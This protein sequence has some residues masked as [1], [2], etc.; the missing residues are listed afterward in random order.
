MIELAIFGS[1]MIL[2]LGV[3]LNYGMNY[4][5]RQEA[6]MR[7]FR[8]ALASAA[9][10]VAGGDPIGSASYTVLDDRHIPNPASPFGIGSAV[11][12]SGSGSVGRSFRRQHTADIE[13]ELPRV[14]L[15]LQGQEVDCPSAGTGCVAAGFRTESGITGLVWDGDT[16]RFINDSGS[17]GMADRYEVVYGA[18]SLEA[19]GPD[20]I[21]I[22]DACDG[23]IIGFEACLLQARMITDNGVCTEQCNRGKPPGS[24]MDCAAICAQPMH[25]PWYAGGSTVF[26]VLD[27]LFGIVRS[28]AQV[29]AQDRQAMGVQP[30]YVKVTNTDS[31]LT[32]TES[33]GGI[34]T[35]DNFGWS[36]TTTRDVVYR[37]L[38]NT[39]GGVTTVKESRSLDNVEPSQT[40]SVSW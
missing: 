23:E 2:T 17:I 14:R 35:T 24:D 7:S 18:L 26:P 13:A 38:G 33:A 22:I 27:G 20:T 16:G 6:L 40:L 15:N 32:K 29:T 3:L 19:L 36:E 37:P 10:P 21:R 5:F 1:L 25:V 31:T 34:S 8:G 11:P 28:G 12:I 39:S 4:D 30:G 9:E